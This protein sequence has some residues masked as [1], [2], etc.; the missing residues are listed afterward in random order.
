MRQ[1]PP[2]HPRMKPRAAV[3][4]L[5]ETQSDYSDEDERTALAHNRLTDLAG[6]P[7]LASVVRFDLARRTVSINGRRD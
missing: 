4:L 7:A 3:L 2:E 5:S 6:M 1:Q